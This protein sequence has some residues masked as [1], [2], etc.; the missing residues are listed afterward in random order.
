MVYIDAGG[1]I[2]PLETLFRFASL[3]ENR[4]AQGIVVLQGDSTMPASVHESPRRA[5]LKGQK[6]CIASLRYRHLV[7]LDGRTGQ[8]VGKPVFRSP[9]STCRH[10]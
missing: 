2:N 5:G 10:A 6:G 4:F 7:N 1:I 3:K 8:Q 9:F